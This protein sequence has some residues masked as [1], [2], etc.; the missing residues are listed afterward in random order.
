MHY[1]NLL[2]VA[3]PHILPAHI[4]QGRAENVFHR[5]QIGKL[6]GA[7]NHIYSFIYFYDAVVWLDLY[8]IE[9]NVEHTKY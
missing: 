2:V 5:T 9:S 4:V 3:A 8:I 6:W 7:Q 1:G